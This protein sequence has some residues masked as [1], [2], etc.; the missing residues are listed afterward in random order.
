MPPILNGLAAEMAEIDSESSEDEDNHKFSQ[1]D[2]VKFLLERKYC[3]LCIYIIN[4]SIK[5][6]NF[7]YIIISFR[8]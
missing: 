4:F 5:F 8:N 7:L 1:P 3:T 6:Y 2:Q